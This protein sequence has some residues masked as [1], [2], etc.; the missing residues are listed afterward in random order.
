M[1]LVKPQTSD[2]DYIITDMNGYIDSCTPGIGQ[3]FNNSSAGN[4]VGEPYNYKTSYNS[5][6]DVLVKDTT[7]FNI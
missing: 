3:H 6:F 2:N 1:G 4:G 5:I 7:Q